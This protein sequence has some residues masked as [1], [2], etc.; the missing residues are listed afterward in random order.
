MLHLHYIGLLNTD[1]QHKG[2]VQ[3]F[4]QGRESQER[5]VLDRLPPWVESLLSHTKEAWA[6]IRYVS[7]ANLDMCSQETREAMYQSLVAEGYQVRQVSGKAAYRPVSE[8][9]VA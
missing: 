4:L 1:H 7:G 9:F 6:D 8:V 2:P 3:M 5:Y